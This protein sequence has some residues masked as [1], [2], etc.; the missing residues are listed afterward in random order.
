MLS[1]FRKHID[2]MR[3]RRRCYV[4]VIVA[5]ASNTVRRGVEQWGVVAAAGCCCHC[6]S[7]SANIDAVVAGAGRERLWEAIRGGVDADIVT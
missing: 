6:S 4:V 3:V 2:W 1:L 7:K 5:A